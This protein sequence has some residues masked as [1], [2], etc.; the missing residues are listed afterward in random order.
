MISVI[1]PVYN[2]RQYLE[3]AM[4]SVLGQS[5][6]DL[7]II[8]IDDGSTDGSGEIC[9]AYQKKDARVRVIH[10]KNQGISAARNTGL[11]I[12]TGE[13]IAF[14]DPDDAFS[15]DAL[16][17]MNQAMHNYNVDIVDCNSAIYIGDLRMD[18]S[19]LA[20]KSKWFRAK[21]DRTG[22]YP[23]HKALLSACR[24]ILQPFV[25]TKLYR[26]KI[27]DK[28]RFPDGHTYEDRDTLLPT[29]YEAQ[30][31]YILDENLVMHRIRAGSISS[32]HSKKNIT[33][34]VCAHSHFIRFIEDHIPQDFDENALKIAA[35]EE[36]RIMLSVYF[37]CANSKAENKKE[38]LAVIGGF[39]SELAKK[40]DV[41]RCPKKVRTMYFLYAH[42]PLFLSS[43]IYKSYSGIV[44][45]MSKR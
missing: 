2:V 21:D 16:L 7:E 15:K 19:E 44:R 39:I 27:W 40:A 32:T 37:D 30:S 36:L 1:I 31:V 28:V 5:F 35:N 4:E 8:L 43:A 29:L 17:K 26:R 38:S 3:E 13:T 42:L 10:Q 41:N 6:K 23:R 33:D 24:G 18:E 20:Q 14:L 9:D 45:L 25:W 34:R 22:L 11:N 12:C